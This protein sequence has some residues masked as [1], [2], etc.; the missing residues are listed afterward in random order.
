MYLA[1]IRKKG[2]HVANVKLRPE[3]PWLVRLLTLLTV[4]AAAIEGHPADPTALIVGHPQP[5]CHTVPL[6]DFYLH[7][8]APNVGRVP[9][10]PDRPQKLL[11]ATLLAAAS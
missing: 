11:E 10:T 8:L 7:S 2:V 6:L 9:N 4:R 1:R 3:E 5:G